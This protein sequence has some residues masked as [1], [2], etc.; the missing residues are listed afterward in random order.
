[1]IS[2]SDERKQ[3]D[4]F[5]RSRILFVFIGDM[6]IDNVSVRI[7]KSFDVKSRHILRLVCWRKVQLK[8]L[9]KYGDRGNG[10]ELS[11]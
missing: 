9:K 10:I 3:L 4:Y 7:R 8:G 11:S 2:L 5:S 6:R 1:M